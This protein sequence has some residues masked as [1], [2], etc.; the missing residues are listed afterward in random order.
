MNECLKRAYVILLFLF[1]CSIYLCIRVL[2]ARIV[3]T[4]CYR[5]ESIYEDLRD[6]SLKA[7]QKYI[8]ERESKLQE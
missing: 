1:Y 7:A 5:R 8:E 6:E 4:V 3:V 2:V